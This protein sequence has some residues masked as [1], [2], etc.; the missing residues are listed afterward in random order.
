M[1][2]AGA[3]TL[4]CFWPLSIMVLHVVKNDGGFVPFLGEVSRL[5]V[6][7]KKPQVPSNDN[8]SQTITNPTNG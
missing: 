2:A 7:T 3:D 6:C 8:L 1:F 5:L 4:K